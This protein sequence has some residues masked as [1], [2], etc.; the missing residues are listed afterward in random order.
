MPSWISTTNGAQNSK[1]KLFLKEYSHWRSIPISLT[2][3]WQHIC[4]FRYIFIPLSVAVM[5][6]KGNKPVKIEKCN[7]KSTFTIL[8]YV[9]LIHKM[10]CPHINQG[11]KCDLWSQVKICPN[12]P[13]THAHFQTLFRSAHTLQVRKCDNTH[14]CAATQRLVKNMFVKICIG[15]RC[16]RSQSKIKTLLYNAPDS[17]FF[18]QLF[19]AVVFI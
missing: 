6:E 5:Y 3:S 7:R 15:L 19:S 11:K 1:P 16:M 18:I 9:F 10:V 8:I 17:L 2:I 13:T 4:S 14:M 12:E